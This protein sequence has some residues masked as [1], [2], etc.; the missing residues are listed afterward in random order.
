MP[1]TL[2]GKSHAKNMDEQW[3]RTIIYTVPEPFPF[4][5]RRQVIVQKHSLELSPIEVAI[6][7]INDRI[8]SFK[9]E[10]N[11][12]LVLNNIMRL[13]QGSVLPQVC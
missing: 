3:K 8:I 4:V 6:D 13:I 12:T 5:C 2:D 10:L 1:F 7:D 9:Q 11:G